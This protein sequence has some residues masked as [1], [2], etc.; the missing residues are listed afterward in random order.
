MGGTYDGG[1][2]TRKT[3]NMASSARSMS[4]FVEQ[5]PGIH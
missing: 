1:D 5:F 3:H 2:M 4:Y